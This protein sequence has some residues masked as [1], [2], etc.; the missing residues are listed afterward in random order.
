MARTA[1]REPDV[2]LTI[3]TFSDLLRIVETRPEWRRKMVKALFPEVD[4]PKAL[5]EL[6]EQQR[7]TEATIQRLGEQIEAGFAA[8]AA[9]RK[10]LEGRMET[11]FTE[12]TDERKAL[13]GRVEA[14]FAAAAKDRKEMRQTLGDLKGKG[15]EQYYHRRADAI[16]GSYLKGGRKVT[17]PVG[18]R[19]HDAVEAGA[20]S[21]QQR[22]QVMAADLLWGGR[23]YKTGEKVILV[24]EASWLAEE[25]DVSRAVKRA[26]ILREI[27]LKALPV[28]AAAEWAEGIPEMAR[29]HEMVMVTGGLVDED[30]WWSAVANDPNPR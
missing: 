22:V 12:A 17:S 6:A 21:V 7:R 19:L 4:V 18:E 15:R 10:A 16:F 27:G 26:A 13:E 8:A 25:S 5:Q 20:I 24:V 2:S 23:L 3:T 11:G 1:L 28:V 9:E 30:S 29:E 14:G